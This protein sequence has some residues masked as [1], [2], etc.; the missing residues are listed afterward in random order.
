MYPGKRSGAANR[1][2]VTQPRFGEAVG[3]RGR[4]S[5][6]YETKAKVCCS[7][8]YLNIRIFI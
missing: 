2:L 3:P 6:Q 8:L 1:T 4:F 5:Y 7:L